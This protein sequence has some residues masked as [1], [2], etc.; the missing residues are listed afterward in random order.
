MVGQQKRARL[1]YEREW[2]V[3]GGR[4][5][6]FMASHKTSAPMRMR[7]M[8]N[9]FSPSGLR[10]A[11]QKPTLCVAI[12]EC[13]RKTPSAPNRHPSHRHHQY[14]FTGKGDERQQS[15]RR[16]SAQEEIA[17][18][19]TADHAHHRPHLQSP[20]APATPLLPPPPRLPLRHACRHA[21]GGHYPATGVTALRRPPPPPPPQADHRR[22]RAGHPL[23]QP[24]V[25]VAAA[26]AAATAAELGLVAAGGGGEHGPQPT[27]RWHQT[28][29]QSRGG[30]GACGASSGSGGGAA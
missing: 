4:T 11:S 17:P 5:I 19:P 9:S 13:N 14:D 7:Y 1:M 6:Y 20:Q 8:E 12:Q 2:E 18:P 16:C 28:G 15:K 29:R 24:V 10:S 22:R 23:T 21:R 25:V 27:P 26:V 3:C 30:G